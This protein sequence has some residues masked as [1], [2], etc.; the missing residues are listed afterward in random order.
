MHNS[1]AAARKRRT[2]QAPLAPPPPQQTSHNNR[3]GPTSAFNNHG[4]LQNHAGPN[5]N[6]QTGH[7]Q[8]QQSGTGQIGLTLQ[9]VI[10]LID[11]RLIALETFMSEIQ[12]EAREMSEQLEQQMQ[13]HDLNIDSYGVGD[14]MPHPTPISRRSLQQQQPT[15][16]AVVPVSMP[17][18]IQVPASVPASIQVPASAP[19]TLPVSVPMSVPEPVVPVIVPTALSVPVPASVPVPV[20]VPNPAPAQ[21]DSKQVRDNQDYKFGLLLEEMTSLKSA[22]LNLQSYTMDVNRKLFEE[23]NILSNFVPTAVVTRRSHATPLEEEEEEE[24]EEVEPED[25]DENNTIIELDEEEIETDFGVMN[26]S[27]L[28][29]DEQVVIDEIE[30]DISFEALPTPTASLAS[31]AATTT[32][33]DVSSTTLPS[34]TPTT[35]RQSSSSSSS[36]SGGRQRRK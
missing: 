34:S 32:T 20:E 4:F 30:M 15:P 10:T 23:R 12:Q 5:R 6:M 7:Q 28:N 31:V 1:N 14:E 16:A 35:T 19:V 11:R 2:Q 27:I 24:G 17:A 36:K 29:V 13:N 33:D 22:L 18:N 25:Q 21:Q 3:G 9:Q 26:E 8:Q